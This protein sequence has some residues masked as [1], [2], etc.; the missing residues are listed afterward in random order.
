M[1]VSSWA[2]PKVIAKKLH[3]D[4]SQSHP[5]HLDSC[6]DLGKQAHSCLLGPKFLQYICRIG[7]MVFLPAR[8]KMGFPL[9]VGFRTDSHNQKLGIECGPEGLRSVTLPSEARRLPRKHTFLVQR[10]LISH[11]FSYLLARWLEPRDSCVLRKC[12]NE[13]ATPLFPDFPLY[14]IP[15]NAQPPKKFLILK[16]GEKEAR[17]GDSTLD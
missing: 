6:T 1:A 2:G 10:A 13:L 16:W 3:S 5:S 4:R 15:K 12:S 8:P 14:T 17:Q 9:A 7:R 11:L